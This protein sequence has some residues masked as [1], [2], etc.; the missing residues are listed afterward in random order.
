[1]KKKIITTEWL[2]DV[3]RAVSANN[4]YT[5][6]IKIPREAEGQFVTDLL[7]STLQ[8]TFNSVEKISDYDYEVLFSR[9]IDKRELFDAAADE[10]SFETEVSK[11]PYYCE[12]AK[13]TLYREV[14]DLPSLYDMTAVVYDDVYHDFVEHLQKILGLEEI[15]PY[16]KI[17]LLSVDDGKESYLLEIDGDI[18]M[19]VFKELFPHGS[20]VESDLQDVKEFL[21]AKRK[22]NDPEGDLQ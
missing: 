20:F 7:H 15:S 6:L 19:D 5:K 8:F 18:R 12:E 10:Y 17:K 1:M 2:V 13:T 3:L 22:G 9:F 11:I 21:E 16:A 4:P 14:H